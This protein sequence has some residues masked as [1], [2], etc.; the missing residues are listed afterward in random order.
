[1]RSAELYFTSDTHFGHKMMAEKIRGFSS[2]E[3]MDEE[4]IR[5]WNAVIPKN[6]HVFH[7]G[8]LSF[9][10]R[11]KTESILARLNGVKYLVSG[12]HD[13]GSKKAYAAF[14]WIKPYY[15]LTVEDTCQRIVMCHYAFRV[16]NR[17]HYGAWNLHGHS[18]GNLLPEIWGQ[19]DVGVDTNSLV[20]YTYADVVAKMALKPLYVPADHHVVM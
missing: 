8:D 15:E 4:L 3:E 16:W 13:H 17:G 1:M 7:L 6:G 20:P 14:Q 10:N 2:S 12:N 5:R 19:L 18:H 9:R 11:P